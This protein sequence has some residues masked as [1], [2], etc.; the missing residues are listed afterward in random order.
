MTPPK[1]LL[2]G[3]ILRPHGIRGELRMRIL[4]D[5][6]E[7]VKDLPSVFLG[8]SPQD[9]KPKKHHVKS[10]RLHQDYLLITLKEVP[11][12]DKAEM[13]RGLF[14]MVDIREAV[15]LED[16]E[17][18]LFQLIGMRVETEN[19]EFLGTVTDVLETGANDVYIIDSPAYGEVLLPV[20]D[21]T[22]TK[23]DTETNTMTVVIPEGLIENK[24]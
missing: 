12:R 23:T 17:I 3:E 22:I 19:G 10:A 6:P 11:D 4:T 20:I 15:P 14:V 5:Y 16:D 1:Y 13:M 8:T 21:G 18:Y 7:R 2:I 9:Q 24:K